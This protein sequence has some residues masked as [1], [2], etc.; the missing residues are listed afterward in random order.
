MQT[1]TDK[2]DPNQF[3]SGITVLKF[4]AEWCQPCKQMQP[5][6]EQLEAEHP[7]IAFAKADIEEAPLA[8]GFYNVRSVPT[9]LVLK[10]GSIHGL[11]VGFKSK[12]ALSA[13]IQ[14]VRGAR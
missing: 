7:D 2:S 6:M 9:V 1:I 8:A 12:S 5:I 11:A 14:A 3:N 4:G 10:D 13:M